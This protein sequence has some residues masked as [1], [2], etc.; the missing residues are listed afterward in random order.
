M[1]CVTGSGSSSSENFEK[2]FFDAMDL[3][4]KDVQKLNEL[5]SRLAS[6]T[7]TRAKAEKC[8]MSLKMII[9]F[10]EAKIKSMEQGGTGDS[11]DNEEIARLKSEISALQTM[12]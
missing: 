12:V 6:A 10:R 4:S 9:K 11:D 7:N 2:L 3:W 5:E 8:T 1:V